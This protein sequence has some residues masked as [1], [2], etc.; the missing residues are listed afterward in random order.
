MSAA[1]S[2]MRL[3]VLILGLAVS[4]CAGG[5]A[6]IPCDALTPIRPAESDFDAMSD[7]LV[8][9]ILVYNETGRRI[10]GWQP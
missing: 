2:K 6:G 5:P 10:C 9:Q 3:A 4:A 1:K 8:G 7:L